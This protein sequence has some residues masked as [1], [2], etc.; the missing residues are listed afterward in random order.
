[1]VARC[2][3]TPTALRS[4]EPVTTELCRIAEKAG[5]SDSLR[6]DYVGSRARK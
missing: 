5:Y 6:I 1:M 2:E 4:R 3:E